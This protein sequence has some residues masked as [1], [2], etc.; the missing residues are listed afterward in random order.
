MSLEQ[1]TCPKCH[2][3]TDCETVAWFSSSSRDLFGVG[4]RCA[5]CGERKL[6][7]SPIGPVRI[8]P[9]TCLQCGLEGSSGSTPCANCGCFLAMVLSEAQLRR[10]DAELLAL[11]REA[12]AI[13]TCRRGLTIT[14][15][16]LQR[17]PANAEAN[18]IRSDFGDHLNH[19]KPFT[20]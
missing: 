15:Y 6:V 18:K 20:K 8:G 19:E 4:W 11:A 7:V 17:N 3:P 12:F 5:S 2:R 16:V 9:R 1:P 13:G 10:P 14:N